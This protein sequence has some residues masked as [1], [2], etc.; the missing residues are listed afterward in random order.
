LQSPEQGKDAQMA[1]LVDALCSGRSVRKDVLV[2]IQFW[3]LQK[4]QSVTAAFLFYTSP[5]PYKKI[6]TEVE[7]DLLY[8]Y[9]PSSF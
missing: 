3:A 1:K 5:R 9:D 7:I 4:K 2:R 8:S 6:K